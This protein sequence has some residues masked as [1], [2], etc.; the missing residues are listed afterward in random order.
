REERS[1]R[2]AQQDAR[3]IPGQ[4]HSRHR[5]V[6]LQPEIDMLLRTLI[7]SALIAAAVPGQSLNPS[8]LTA[9]PTDTWPMYNG[10]Y[11]GRRFST[12][13]KVNDSNINSLSL[14]WVYRLNVGG[15]GFGGAIKATPVQVD[16]VLYFTLPDH[17]W[18]VD[19]RTGKE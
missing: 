17:A 2:D 19:A 13:T 5:C 11:S 7:T 1:G 15:G 3:S 10:D 6:P 16:G 12:L 14:A 9:P 8:K 18:A 4:R